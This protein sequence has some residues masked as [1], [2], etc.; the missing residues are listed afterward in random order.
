MFSSLP[1]LVHSHSLADHLLCKKFQKVTSVAQL[2]EKCLTQTGVWIRFDFA[3]SDPALCTV[4]CLAGDKD[5]CVPPALPPQNTVEAK[6]QE[7]RIPVFLL[8]A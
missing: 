7:I 6:G 8:T 5:T 2:M 1:F 4:L 3:L